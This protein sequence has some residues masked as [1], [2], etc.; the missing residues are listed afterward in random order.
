[1]SGNQDAAQA[2][3][4]RA[5]TIDEMIRATS[6]A[7]LGMTVGCARCHDHKFDPILQADYYTFYSIFAGV[8]HGERQVGTPEA[9][10]QRDA[11]LQPLVAARDEV[12]RQRN[13]LQA[14]IDAR[15]EAAAGAIEPTWTRPPVS[16]Y[17]TE[18][19]FAP[20]EAKFIRLTVLSRD[21]DPN[22]NTGFRIDEFE[23]L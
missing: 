4:I 5:N 8:Q 13:E 20:T 19:T 18:E 21:N 17:L 2:A 16:R 22:G 10:A 11:A 6:E 3:I 23:V 14:A 15:A 7:F 9:Q 12:Q 1:M